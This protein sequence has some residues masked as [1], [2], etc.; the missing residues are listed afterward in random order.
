[1]KTAAQRL[2]AQARHTVEER[3]RKVEVHTLLRVADPRDL[4][5]EVS[6]QADMVVLGSRGRGPVRSLLLGSV[7]AAVTRHASCPVVVLRPYNSGLVRRGVLVGVDGS[8][9]SQAPL[10]FAFRQASQRCLPLTVVHAFHEVQAPVT[11]G[12][13]MGPVI[14]QD[15][16]EQRLLL[17]EALSGMRE[18]FPDVPVRTELVHGGAGDCLVRMSDQMNLVVVGAHHGGVGSVIMFG[19]VAT[20]VVEHASCPVAVVPIGEAR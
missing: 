13:P 11:Y 1:M 18:K 9:R 19:S 12:Q 4:L 14:V 10:E 6:R 16:E 5:M 17:A 2:L 3:T 8:E 7:G 15:V 20:S